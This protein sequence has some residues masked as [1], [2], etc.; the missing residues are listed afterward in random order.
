MPTLSTLPP[1]CAKQKELKTDDA[2]LQSKVIPISAVCRAA[3]AVTGPFSLLYHGK[4][5]FTRA[6]IILLN[7]HR[8]KLF[9]STY[10]CA[11][12]LSKL[13]RKASFG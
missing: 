12:R 4:C 7:E 13:T 11:H 1:P 8:I 5:F 9:L 10:R 2:F 3:L 6:T